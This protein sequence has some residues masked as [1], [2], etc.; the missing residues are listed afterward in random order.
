MIQP[1]VGKQEWTTK[2]RV[3]GFGK[4]NKTNGKQTYGGS[5]QFQFI[6]QL[7]DFVCKIKVLHAIL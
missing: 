5:V 4:K 2:K 7:R 3:N 6:L 1:G